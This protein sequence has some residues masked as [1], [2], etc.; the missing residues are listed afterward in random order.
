MT[1]QELKNARENM[2]LDIGQ[3]AR[4]L[5]TPRGTYVKWENGQ[6]RVP[7][8]LDVLL[9][10][11]EPSPKNFSQWWQNE[12]LLQTNLWH[13]YTV[14]QID[15]ADVEMIWDAA[16]DHQ[17]EVDANIN[18]VII[19]SHTENTKCDECVAME[20]V[21]RDYKMLIRSKG[22]SDEHRNIEHQPKCL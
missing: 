22:G 10:V 20:D 14:N 8:F 16:S 5:N 9:P 7:G 1:R 4:R 15:E 18:L 6:R 11:Y 13:S 3:M 19:C 21:I 17:R 12:Y 2:G